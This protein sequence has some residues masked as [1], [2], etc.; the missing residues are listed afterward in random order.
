MRKK[1]F[2]TFCISIIL[3]FLQVSII[4]GEETKIYTYGK[5]NKVYIN[6]ILIDSYH[7]SGHQCIIA[8]DL[9]NYGFNVTWNTNNKVLNINR[10]PDSFPSIYIPRV[11][12]SIDDSKSEEY[13]LYKD[14]RKVDYRI[15]MDGIELCN[16]R[17]TKDGTLIPIEVL[18][19]YGSFKKIEGE[20]TYYYITLSYNYPTVT[21]P[22][23]TAIKVTQPVYDFARDILLKEVN[24][25]TSR[26]L[27]TYVYIKEPHLS[28][29][30]D[31]GSSVNGGYSSQLSEEEI[32]MDAAI[33]NELNIKYN[34]SDN[35]LT[36]LSIPSKEIRLQYQNIFDFGEPQ[37]SLILGEYR[38][39]KIA[40]LSCVDLK[41]FSNETEIKTE[42]KFPSFLDY[43]G[44]LVI[45]LQD[46][47]QAL[48][49]DF[50][51][52]KIKDSEGQY[53]NYYKMT[54][55]Q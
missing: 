47:S 33:L 9:N 52:E 38:P 14:I 27:G 44:N 18:K 43:N 40:E 15:L 46:L 39:D 36:I 55:K 37:Y 48:N 8:E 26:M 13:I 32:Y 29:I 45:K 35:K 2:L 34:I 31:I 3:C 24:P 7:Y 12:N 30:Q 50:S 42:N 10:I 11:R 53:Q 4:Y 28:G 25:D 16:A 51:V 22:D 6:E 21:A 19:K 23:G 17:F 1:L 54:P 20:T 5:S 41:L 49:M